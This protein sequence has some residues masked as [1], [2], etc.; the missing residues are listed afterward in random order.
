M[1]NIIK[2]L[3]DWH[4]NH[5]AI[6]LL[7]MV[8]MIWINQAIGGGAWTAA[9]MWTV[10]YYSREVSMAGYLGLGRAFLPWLWAYH[11]RVQT[12]WAAVVAFTIAAAWSW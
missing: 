2:W 7:G 1:R 9:L 10:I 8:P 5:A 12:I 3:E 4:L 11:D 6:V